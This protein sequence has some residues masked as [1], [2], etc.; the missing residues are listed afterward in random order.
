MPAATDT[1]ITGGPATQAARIAEH[2][3]AGGVLLREQIEK[4][5][6]V[7][8]PLL[9]V[10]IYA[11]HLNVVE[12]TLR[13]AVAQTQA[14]GTPFGLALASA[15]TS[16]ARHRVGELGPAEAAADTCLELAPEIGWGIA[17]HIAAATMVSVL[18]ERGDLE[19][20]QAVLDRLEGTYDPE[21]TTSQVLRESR[22]K[23]HMA[24]GDPQAAL[25]ELLAVARWEQAMKI[26]GTVVRYRGAPRR[27][28]HTKRSAKQKPH[29]GSPKKN[30][31]W[32]N[33][34][35][36]PDRSASPCASSGAW[37]PGIKASSIWKQL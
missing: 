27:R 21:L 11:G 32:P 37:T 33:D 29:T 24:R 26:P 13:Q 4:D 35:Q 6:P 8:Y 31:C 36:R 20:A 9:W 34:S 7:F 16:L 23:L 15:F 17:V 19:R 25:D 30:S 12:P 14:R 22:A 1:V 18:V 28:S 3:L 2:T 10:L 5:Q